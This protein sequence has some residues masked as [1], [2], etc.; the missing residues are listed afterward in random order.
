MKLCKQAETHDIFINA[1]IK[2]LLATGW[3]S[4]RGRQNVASYLIHDLEISWIEGA[5]FFEEYLID[6]D[7]TNNYRNWKYIAG[8]VQESKSGEIFN[9]PKQTSI[10]DPEGTYRKFWHT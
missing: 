5:K 4:N 2:E 3:M 9:I 1:N 8:T 10:Y 6:Y 7:P